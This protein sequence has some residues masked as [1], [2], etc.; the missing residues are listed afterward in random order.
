MI[1]FLKK[2]EESDNFVFLNY[3]SADEFINDKDSSAYLIIRHK[4][5]DDFQFKITR[6]IDEPDKFKIMAVI[7]TDDTNEFSVNASIKD[8][9]QIEKILRLTSNSLKDCGLRKYAK[10]LEAL[11]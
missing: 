7:I 9:V 5:T 2:V 4:K 6:Y 10:D 8:H 3:N 11:K 1:D